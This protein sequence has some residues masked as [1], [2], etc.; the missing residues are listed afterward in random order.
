M[1]NIVVS[2]ICIILS[3]ASILAVDIV[4]DGKAVAEIV[5]AKDATPAAKTSGEE[6]Q[7]HL[8]KISGAKLNVVESPSADV[9]NQI[10]V[11]ESEF[12]RKLGLNLSDVKYDGYKIIAKGNYLILAG[13]DLYHYSKIVRRFS[14]N[15]PTQQQWEEDSG[16]RWRRPSFFD[17]R[18]YSKEC[19]FHLL[20]GTGSLY[21]TYAFLESLG[22]RWFMPSEE[23]GIVYPELKNITVKDQNTKVEPEFGQ[24]KFSDGAYGENKRDFLWLKSLKAGTNL[25][26]PIYHSTGRLLDAHPE[27]MPEEYFGKVKGKVNHHIPNY[28]SERYRG[29]FIKYLDMAD[30]FLGGMEYACI[31]QPD[32]WSQLGD[33]DVAAGWDKFDERGPK[34]RFSDYLW[35]FVMDIRK[36]YKAKHPDKKF[37][38]FAYSGTQRVPTNVK[39]IPDDIT[40]VLCQSARNWMLAT[41]REQFDIR[42]EWLKRLKGKDKLLVWE[43]YLEHTPRY[44]TP[45]MPTMFTK[46][47][48]ESFDGLYD[49]AA[50]FLVESGWNQGK[51][52][53]K[54]RIPKP[55]ISSY[56]LYLHSKL[57]WDRNTKLEDVMDDYCKNFFGPAEKEMKGFYDFCEEVWTRP[58]PREITM[59]GGYIK[60]ED[61]KKFFDIFASAKKKTGDSIYGKRID[62]IAET[63]EP[64]KK[65]HDKLERTGPMVR[66][67]YAPEKPV[68]DGDLTQS[69]W[70]NNKL[71]NKRTIFG[72]P[73]HT[74]HTLRDMVTGRTPKHVSTKVSFRWMPDNSALIVGIEC[75]EPH[76]DR[77]VESCKDRDSTSIFNDDNI[78]V[79]LETMAGLSP[80]IVINS[81]GVV[82]DY[83]LSKNL[84][85]LPQWYTVDEVAVKKYDDRWTVELKIDAAKIEGKKPSKNFPWGV[86]ICRQR[87][88]SNTTEYYMLSPS[89][90]SFK[91]KKCMGNL[92]LRK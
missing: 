22:M 41:G 61:V 89:G 20:D 62:F 53:E 81:A 67:Y 3:S 51:A 34:G 59:A 57:C 78:E 68:I 25:I 74:W 60:R 17:Y 58:E 90:T 36:R 46:T 92:Y 42:K 6:L 52:R 88:A 83:C 48:K 56:N 45:P 72:K 65:L 40:I 11:G 71:N 43:Y 30:K 31:G 21:A 23:L 35:N 82:Y 5:V 49:R 1:R 80:K 10:Y 84:A 75:Y 38:V 7:K 8:E 2:F 85:D 39:E 73:E 64:L 87:M 50:G 66:A 28:M 79:N 33:V 24:R 77:L 55:A 37:T 70:T 4:K 29:D 63:M 54:N 44:N 19:D 69:F 14:R 27:E 15:K 13:V 47:M 26:M 18:D 91:V 16:S 12:T 9:A 32:G 76:M 86:N